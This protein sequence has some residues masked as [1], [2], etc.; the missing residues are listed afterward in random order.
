M[1]AR[2]I[3]DE[4]RQLEA[5]AFFVPSL[6]LG[7]AVFLLSIIVGRVIATQRAQMAPLKALGHRNTT[8][9]IHYLEFTAIVVVCGAMLEWGIGYGLGIGMLGMCAD[10]YRFARIDYYLSM[11]EMVVGILLALTDGCLATLGALRRAVHLQPAE[12]MQPA[13]PA[14][15]HRTLVERLGHD[16][17][18]SPPARMV[19]R[20]LSRRPLR[21]LASCMGVSFGVALLVTD[22]WHAACSIALDSRSSQ[23]IRFPASNAAPLLTEQAGPTAE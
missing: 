5:T 19:L 8:I 10:Y 13:A 7:V 15:D 11:R 3:A 2:F 16:Q 23:A 17:V 14:I 21:A 12:A 1:S 6:F 4:F 22:M 9:A 20:N 18:L